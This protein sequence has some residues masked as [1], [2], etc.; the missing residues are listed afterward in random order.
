[1]EIIQL[2]GYSDREK[3]NI[4]K[5]YLIARQTTENGLT[6]ERLEITDDAIN[7]LT[8]RYTREAGVRQLERTIGNLARKVALK[9]AESPTPDSERCGRDKIRI[10][11]KDVK[12]YL[13]GLVFIPNRG[14]IAGVS[15]PGWLDREG[16]EVLFI[17]ASSF[18][19]RGAH[20]D[21]AIGEVMKNRPTARSYLWAL[22]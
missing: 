16:G 5:Q 21:I 22:P 10:P 9:V 6:P 17:E 4:A 12:D 11:A 15:R 3:L 1:M 8:A 19:A 7:L 13:G 2:A 18:L 14:G 20:T